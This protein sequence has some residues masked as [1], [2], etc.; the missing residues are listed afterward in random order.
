MID[1]RLCV[2][3]SEEDL[4]YGLLAGQAYGCVGYRSDSAFAIMRNIVL[5][6]AGAGGGGT[7]ATTTVAAA[8]G[9]ATT[10]PAKA[11]P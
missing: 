9:P 10:G 4:S 1:G 2:L 6:A 5:Y 8:S 11:G 7:P 3:F